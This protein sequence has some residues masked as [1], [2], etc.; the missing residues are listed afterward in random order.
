MP[1]YGDFFADDESNAVEKTC[2]TGFPD[3][4]CGIPR[5]ERMLTTDKREIRGFCY[6]LTPTSLPQPAVSG[7]HGTA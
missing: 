6:G 1:I 4:P 2:A 5:D 3:E 7:R